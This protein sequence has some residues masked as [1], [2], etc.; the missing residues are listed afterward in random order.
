MWTKG[1]MKKY[2]RLPIILATF[3]L[4]Q[5]IPFHPLGPPTAPVKG[6]YIIRDSG[7]SSGLVGTTDLDLKFASD[8]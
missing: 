5:R 1:V 7:L 4:S 8:I 3:G 6:R 2:F